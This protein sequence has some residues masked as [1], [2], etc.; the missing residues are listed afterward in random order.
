MLEKDKHKKGQTE[1]KKMQNAQKTVFGGWGKVDF[2]KNGFLQKWEILT[3]FDRD[4]RCTSLFW[5]Y[6]FFFQKRPQDPV[7]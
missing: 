4:L 2:A 7:T 5:P 6:C 1:N 3:V